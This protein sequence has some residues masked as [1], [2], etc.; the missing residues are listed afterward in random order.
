MLKKYVRKNNQKVGMLVAVPFDDGVVCI[1][2]SKVNTKYDK[3]DREI[4]FSLAFTR[5]VLDTDL[6][7][8]LSIE[9]QYYKFVNRVARYYKDKLVIY[10]HSILVP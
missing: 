5:A 4:A 7:V 2:W 9:S 6:P 1:G 8:P 10:N 3:F